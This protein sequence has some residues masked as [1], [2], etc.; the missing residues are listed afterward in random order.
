MLMEMDELEHAKSYYVSAIIS[1]GLISLGSSLGR[2][3]QQGWV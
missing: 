3:L 1:N 2:L